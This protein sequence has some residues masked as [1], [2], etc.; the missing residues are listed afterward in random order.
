MLAV[1]RR[2]RIPLA[3]F[4][5]TYARSA[6]PGGQRVNK[7]ETKAVLRWRVKDSPSLP[8]D[9]RERFLARY[10]RR[11]SRA[12]ELLLS[13]Q[14][15]RDRERNARDCLEKLKKMLLAVASPPKRRRPTAPSPRARE[16]RLEEKRV[17]SEK[18]KRR[19][20]PAGE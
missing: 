19:R 14:R 18:K 9:V 20:P 3:E 2:I 16:R 6:G 1:T 15:Y 10:G 11:V 7:V 5:F 12:G 4:R 8:G 17:R 13:S